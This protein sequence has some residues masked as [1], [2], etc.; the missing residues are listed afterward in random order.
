ML[1]PVPLVRDYTAV[2]VMLSI[3]GLALVLAAVQFL[4][5]RARGVE[6]AQVGTYWLHIFPILCLLA[7]AAVWISRCRSAP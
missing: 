6:G 1:L 5:A 4:V 3:A 2:I 7:S